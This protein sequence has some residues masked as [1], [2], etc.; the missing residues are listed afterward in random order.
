MRVAYVHGFAGVSGLGL[1]GA[2]IDAGVPLANV[3]ETWQQLQLPAVQLVRQ[4]RAVA[5]YTATCLSLQL[6]SLTTFLARYTYTSLCEFIEQ[7]I[8]AVRPAQRLLH[9]LTH[10]TATLADRHGEQDRDL[11]LQ[12]DHLPMLLY[13]ASGVA[14]GLEALSIDQILAA[15][16]NLGAGPD[17]IT[18]SLVQGA[19]VYGERTADAL[20][21]VDGAAILV[22]LV[23]SFGPLPMVTLNTTGHGAV[24]D[25]TGN[26][27]RGL[28]V[29][30]GETDAPVGEDRIAVLETNI[31]DMNPEF[32]DVIFEHA[33]AQGALDV[34]LTPI[35]MKKGR[36]ANQLTVL[37]PLPAVHRLSRL[38]LQETSTFGVR[39]YEAWR[40][41]L[42]RFIR[43][44]ETRYG[45]IAVKCGVLD[46]HIV[47]AAPEYDACK[48][49]A[50]T[51]G[52]AVRLV[53]AEA[54]R[55]AAAW[56]TDSD[57]LP[58]TS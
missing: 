50:Q 48:H 57:T 21:T 39:V 45:P 12:C 28:Q 38:L 49:I 17:A 23:A 25:D 40:H 16:I 30:I 3:Q 20:T 11:V 24:S 14:A 54:A 35:L 19:T 33:F 44:V 34:T 26:R 13:M 7:Q 31:D 58:P 56:L 43:Q 27:L 6:P 52:I 2:L 15:P 32:Y 47:Q 1:L 10:F 51:Q 36:P 18:A 22:A 55:L 53:Y 37:A 5:G 42:D 9:V 4:R 29:M 8:T 41:K 46:G